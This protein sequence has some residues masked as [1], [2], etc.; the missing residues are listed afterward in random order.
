MTKQRMEKD[1]EPVGV[2]NLNTYPPVAKVA[3]QQWHDDITVN[4]ED[5][6]VSTPSQVRSQ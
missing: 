4:K 2:S 1:T 3:Q 5:T 6:T